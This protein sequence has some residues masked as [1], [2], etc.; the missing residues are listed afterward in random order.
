[1]EPYKKSFRATEK[2][3]RQ[4]IGDALADELVE[5]AKS[6][7]TTRTDDVAKSVVTIVSEI[8][9]IENAKHRRGANTTNAKKRDRFA[10]YQDEV[11]RL[12][13]E[14][15]KASNGTI[16]ANAANNLRVSPRTIRRR[17]KI[18]GQA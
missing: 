1:M 10:D 16:V 4:E 7:G 8:F 13:R 15:P 17:C 6:Q 9:E 5:L 2:K 11:D 3:A 12:R 14:R 18:P